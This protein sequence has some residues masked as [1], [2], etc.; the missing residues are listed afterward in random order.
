MLASLLQRTCLPQSFH[1]TFLVLLT[2]RLLLRNIYCPICTIVL[3]FLL[4]ISFFLPMSLLKDGGRKETGRMMDFERGCFSLLKYNIFSC[5]EYVYTTSLV[6]LT[7]SV[8]L[9]LRLVEK[10]KQKVIINNHSCRVNSLIR[11]GKAV[12]AAES[13]SQE[14][15]LRAAKA[16]KK[17]CNPAIPDPQGLVSVYSS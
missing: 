11:W 6:S 15:S 1:G 10:A 8:S 2:P 7:K 14:S 4:E 12:W 16:K 9:T 17:P 3:L 13:R 5:S